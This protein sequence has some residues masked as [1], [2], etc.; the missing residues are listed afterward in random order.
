MKKLVLVMVVL[1]I[2]AAPVVFA[3]GQEEGGTGSKG[4]IQVGVS[5]ALFDDMWLTNLRD[6]IAEYA[7]E[8][9]DLE[10][11]IQDGKNDTQVQL[12]QVENFIAQDFD[13][14]IV[15]PVDTD[16]TSSVTK[17]CV[18]AGVPLIYVNRAPNEE[19]PKGVY[20]VV[21]DEEVA[22]R[23][24]GEVLAEKLGGK[25]NVV[26]M[27]GELSHSGTHGR[28]R[29]VKE[30]FN[31]YPD[32][33]I[34]DEQTAN[35]KRDEALNLM[36]NWLQT[37][38]KID[39]VASNNDEMAI[40][41]II[42]LKNAGYKPNKDVWVGGVDATADAMDFMKAGDLTV[43]IFQDAVGQGRGAIDTAYR[44]IKGENVDQKVW[45]PFVKVTE[46]NFTEFMK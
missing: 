5:M 41:A 4:K 1:L 9:D 26:V 36:S 2:I 12:S 24:Q 6:A 39:A 14:I 3:A 37:G 42:A 18:N 44:V 35:W 43:S 19:L 45:I 27:L 22:G 21:S 25:G 40:G 33:K 7:K 32:I 46:D 30:V 13:A 28:T 31:K 29:G 15:N 38:E 23:M 20:L 34:I 16:S 11:F 8:I 17:R 10:V